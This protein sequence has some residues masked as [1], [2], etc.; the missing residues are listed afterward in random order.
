MTPA[1]AEALAMRVLAYL[2]S[3]PEHLS[4]F[5]TTTG[6]GPSNLRGRA[7]DPDVLAAVLDYLLGDESLLLAFCKADSANPGDPFR[8]R[9]HLPGFMEPM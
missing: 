3:E 9:R 5:L 8:A 7:A 6:M 4:H 1:T 2:A